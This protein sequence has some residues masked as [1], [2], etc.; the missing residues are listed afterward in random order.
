MRI[1]WNPVYK[2]FHQIRLVETKEAVRSNSKVI[3]TRQTCSLRSSRV[4]RSKGCALAFCFSVRIWY[5]FLISI[6]RG[7]LDLG[8]CMTSVLAKKMQPHGADFRFK[9][10][11]GRRICQKSALRSHILFAST[12][13]M[14][15]PRS[16]LPLHFNIKNIYQIRR[17]K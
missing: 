8:V 13:V 1:Q 6:C 10:V 17:E 9:N 14:H 7:K 12:E 16:D 2:A 3:L 15:T 4:A 5:M 11:F